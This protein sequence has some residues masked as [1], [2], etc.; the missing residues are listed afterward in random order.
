M[1]QTID[2]KALTDEELVQAEK[3]TKNSVFNV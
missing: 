1:K 2:L 3:K